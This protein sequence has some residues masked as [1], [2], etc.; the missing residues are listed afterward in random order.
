MSDDLDIT[1]TETPKRKRIDAMAANST[2]AVLADLFPAVFVAEIWQPHRPLKLGI[3]QDLIDR[4]I[5]KLEECRAVFR[6]YCSRRM[7]QVALAAGGARYGLD[8]NPYGAVTTEEADSARKAVAHIEAKR[9]AQA[10]TARAAAKTARPRKVSPTPSTPR[11]N[12]KHGAPTFVGSQSSTAA[13]MPTA[14][15]GVAR[16]APK[17]LGLSDLKAAAAARREAAGVQS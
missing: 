12:G 4:G 3:H 5:L 1:T 15:R 10:A 16:D 8:G 6:Y 13:E 17:R 2:I 14:A 11:P 9:A 7:Y